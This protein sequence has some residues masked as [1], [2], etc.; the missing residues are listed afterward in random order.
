MMRLPFIGDCTRASG[1]TCN[2]DANPAFASYLKRAQAQRIRSS[3]SH[4]PFVGAFEGDI[5]VTDSVRFLGCVRVCDSEEASLGSSMGAVAMLM[6]RQDPLRKYA[7]LLKQDTN[8]QRD[9]L[10]PVLM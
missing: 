5:F 4:A 8:I 10:S 3:S 1:A 6:R 7:R 9:H 2:P